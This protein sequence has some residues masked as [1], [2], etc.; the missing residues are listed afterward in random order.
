[1][2]LLVLAS[3][4]LEVSL[5]SFLYHIGQELFY[6]LREYLRVRALMRMNKFLDI[7]DNF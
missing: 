1:M 5:V 4:L 2:L 6:D 7:V 3:L